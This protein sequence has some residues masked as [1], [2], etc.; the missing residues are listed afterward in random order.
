MAF[1]G[2]EILDLFSQVFETLSGESR[3]GGKRDA[4]ALLGVACNTVALIDRFAAYLCDGYGLL[5]GWSR[6]A[7]GQ[8]CD[9]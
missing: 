9:D 4:G 8:S 1:I 5:K 3:Y 6:L 2:R 7:T